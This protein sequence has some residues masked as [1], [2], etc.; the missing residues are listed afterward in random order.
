MINWAIGRL[1]DMSSVVDV[2]LAFIFYIGDRRCQRTLKYI[3]IIYITNDWLYY[4]WDI[5]LMWLMVVHIHKHFFLSRYITSFNLLEINFHI[6]KL[7]TVGPWQH[8]KKYQT[9]MCRLLEF[10]Q[11]PDSISYGLSQWFSIVY[12][13]FG[14][15]W[16][17]IK[18]VFVH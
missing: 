6:L 11:W 7:C 14:R 3:L 10:I 4:N 12:F 15:S 13:V 5:M 2:P 18:S 9:K 17:R 16:F 8:V 1:I